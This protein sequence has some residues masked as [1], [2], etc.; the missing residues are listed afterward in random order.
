MPNQTNVKLVPTHVLL[1]LITNSDVLLVKKDIT[2]TTTLVL[3]LAQ[4]VLMPMS[5]PQNVNP[6]MPVVKLVMPVD[7][8]VVMDQ[9]NVNHVTIMLIVSTDLGVAHTWVTSVPLTEPSVTQQLKKSS[10]PELPIVL[11]VQMVPT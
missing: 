1:V 7:L 5:L 3:N 10:F 11:L 6:V 2:S 8:L 9:V 4:M